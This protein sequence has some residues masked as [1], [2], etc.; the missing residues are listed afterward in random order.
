MFQILTNKLISKVIDKPKIVIILSSLLS[1]LM[2]CGIR[3]IKSDDDLKRLLPNDMPSMITFDEIED[4][5]GNFE[6]MFVA[7]GDS[8]KSVFTPEYFKIA[9]NLTNDIEKLDECELVVSVS[10]TS[11]TYFDYSDSSIVVVENFLLS[12][13]KN[14][15]GK[16][17]EISFLEKI[18]AIQ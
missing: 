14:I 15:Y 13:N 3:Y 4:E 7:I 10:N 18:T 6:F 16:K 8:G 12:F 1:I 9:W 2:M 17:I 11:K 5:F